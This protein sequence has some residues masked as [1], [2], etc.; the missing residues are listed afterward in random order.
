M[1]NVYDN[2]KYAKF[3]L[4]STLRRLLTLESKRSKCIIKLRDLFNATEIKIQE[5][6]NLCELLVCE[7]NT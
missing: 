2:K 4:I 5:K 3:S 7:V 6:A 1:Q